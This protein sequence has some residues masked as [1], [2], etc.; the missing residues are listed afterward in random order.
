MVIHRKNGKVINIKRKAKRKNLVAKTILGNINVRQAIPAMNVRGSIEKKRRKR[1]NIDPINLMVL[2]YS[3]ELENS[4]LCLY[5][6]MMSIQ[7]SIVL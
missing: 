1:D 2:S 4:M 5:N 7:Y 3:L 6:I